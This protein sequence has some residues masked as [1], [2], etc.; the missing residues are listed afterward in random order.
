MLPLKAVLILIIVLGHFVYYAKSPVFS[1]F[2]ELG[3]SAVSIFF[4]MSGFG[5]LRSWQLKGRHYLDGFFKSRILGILLPAILFCVLHSIWKR[6]FAIPPQYWFLWVILFDYL[7]FWYCYRFLPPTW[8]LPVLLIGNMLFMAA[9]IFAGFDRCWWICGLSFPTGCLFADIETTLAKSCAE[10]PSR[11]IAWLMGGILLFAGAYLTRKP[12]I[13]P[14]CYV[15]IPWSLAL[16]VC[17]T[18]LDSLKL[19]VLGFL[20]SISYEMY[21]SHVTVLEVLHQVQAV[22]AH[23]WTFVLAV[24]VLTIAVSFAARWLCSMVLRK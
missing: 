17:A 5:C 20:G 23:T 14:L 13:W 22:S 21:L 19:P 24:F 16:L 11:F 4:F 2:H 15:G 9:T 6:G 1:L 10:K 12:W 7:L 18:P 8:R 3:T